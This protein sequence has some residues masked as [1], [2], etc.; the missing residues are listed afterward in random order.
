MVESLDT[1]W[2]NDEGE[3]YNLDL[4]THARDAVE[5][6]LNYEE[7]RGADE[8]SVEEYF[9]DLMDDNTDDV[10][11][12][13]EFNLFYVVTHALDESFIICVSRG[14]V[15]VVFDSILTVTPR[16]GRSLNQIVTD[17]LRGEA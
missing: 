7:N 14:K 16:K 3:D 12:D 8:L 13:M 2:F 5:W 15:G 17:V 10:D 1:I 4:F 11:L 6:M 9:Q